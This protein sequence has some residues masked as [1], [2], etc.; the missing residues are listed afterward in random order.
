V[1]AGAGLSTTNLSEA[2]MMA[3]MIASAQKTFVL[4][5]S[6][7]FGR[8]AFAHVAPFSAVDVLIT[9]EQPTGKLAEELDDAEVDVVVA[10]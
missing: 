7:K 3:E 9:N 1:A 8:S 2:Q 10:Q 6:S 5:D 4:C